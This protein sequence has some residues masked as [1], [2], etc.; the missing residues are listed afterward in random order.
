MDVNKTFR[1]PDLA[2]R[3]LKE[4]SANS[5]PAVL[6]E[7]CGGQTHSLLASGLDQ[8][9]P[10]TLEL[11][12]GPG[13]PVC[14]TPVEMIDKAIHLAENRQVLFT[15]FGDMMRVPGSKGDLLAAKSR[16]A[17]VRMLYSPLDALT[18]AEQH[19][20]KQVVFWAIGFETT[21]PATALA[22][23]MAREKRVKNFSLLVSHVLVPP[24]MRRLL[25]SPQNRVQAFLAAGHVCAVT[26]WQ[27]YQSIAEE[28]HT[29]I[30]VTGFEPVDLLLG[31]HRA[32]QLLRT[33]CARVD[34]AYGRVVRR[35][36]NEAAMK[37]IADV[38]CECDQTW[39]G[40]GLIPAG[41]LRLREEFADYDAEKIFDLQSD[42]K[43]ESGPCISGLIL[44]GLKK[45]SDCPSFC[46]D[47]TPEHPLGAPM[48]SAEG[49][50]AA[51]YHYRTR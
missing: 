30:V 20:D 49:A 43:A 26:G 31:I 24:A 9:L 3:L 7:I 14:V 33:D 11:V 37:R 46:V 4:L 28:F 5:R 19:P 32:M 51:Y 45:P 17:D 8:L 41:G 35:Y 38:Y 34:N 10:P 16:G 13:C 1:N 21:V 29:P 23:W 44:Q 47:C 22:V 39:R 36:G 48:V 40:L 27:P 2:G 42:H 25:A 6:M 18:L 50:C 12:H 15:T